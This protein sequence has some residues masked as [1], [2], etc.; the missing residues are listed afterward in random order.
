MRTQRL[1]LIALG[2]AAHTYSDE[3]ATGPMKT[4][5]EAR[6]TAD[7]QGALA[8]VAET[9]GPAAVEKV[10]EAGTDRFAIRTFRKLD[11]T[12]LDAAPGY[13]CKFAV[14]I[15]VVNGTLRRTLSGQFLPGSDG[16]VFRHET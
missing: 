4:A 10:R 7:V 5:F 1:P 15:D 16:L 3:P 2:M 13:A 9:G 6:L 8:F 11:C 12:R 14:D